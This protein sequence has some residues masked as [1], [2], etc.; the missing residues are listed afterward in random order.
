MEKEDFADSAVDWVKQF[1]DRIQNS[2]RLTMTSYGA[3][4]RITN[5]NNSRP[6]LMKHMTKEGNVKMV[7]D[8]LLKIQ[9]G[10]NNLDNETHQPA[11]EGKNW[12]NWIQNANQEKQ[13]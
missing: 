13:N 10:Q 1:Y 5:V 6:N 9:E 7:H 4:P 2:L 3:T 8:K 11:R 12:N